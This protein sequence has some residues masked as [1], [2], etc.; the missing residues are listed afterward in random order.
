MKKLPVLL[1]SLIALSNPA[2]AQDHFNNAP[3]NALGSIDFGAAAALHGELP[4]S[5][6]A[7]L[8]DMGVGCQSPTT[9]FPEMSEYLPGDRSFVVVREYALSI[10]QEIA[11]DTGLTELQKREEIGLRGYVYGGDFCQ[12]CDCCIITQREVSTTPR[13]ELTPQSIPDG[14][15]FLDLRQ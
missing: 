9:I 12:K 8:C 14:F 5:N 6:I 4:T 2:T 3:G 15:I 11:S 1:A 10:L 7:N 13:I